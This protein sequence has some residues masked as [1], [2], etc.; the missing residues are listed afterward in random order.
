MTRREYKGAAQSAVLT[1]EL[2]GSTSD[3]QLICTDLTNW[4]TGIGG[5]PFFVVVD[6]GTS[7]EE[8][9]LCSS[10]TGNVLTVFDNGLSNG[11]AADGTSITTHL[12]N[13]VVEHIFTATDADEANAHVNATAGVHGV[14]D[15]ALLATQEYVTGADVVVAAAAAAALGAHEADST[16]IHGITDTAALAKTADVVSK[17]NGKVTTAVTTDGVVRNVWTGTGD[18]TGGIDGDIWLKYV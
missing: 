8:K 10:R 14:T 13:A 18:P 6:R 1:T 11:R 17:T 9:I 12:I 4:P 16:N 2:G 3:V 5:R 15:F 7:M